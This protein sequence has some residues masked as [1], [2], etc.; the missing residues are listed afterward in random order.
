MSTKE[1]LVIELYRCFFFS[2]QEI[3]NNLYIRSDR[4]K[5]A[6][7][8]YEPYVSNKDVA[9]GGARG[10]GRWGDL[11]FTSSFTCHYTKDVF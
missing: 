11:Q 8:P 7:V 5:M 1:N 10:Q 4:V 2:I 6:K 9:G 3:F